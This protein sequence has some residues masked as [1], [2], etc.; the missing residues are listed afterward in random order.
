VI[1][2]NGPGKIYFWRAGWCH[3]LRRL[4]LRFILIT[5][6]LAGAVFGLDYLSVALRIP[7]REQF[8]VIRVDQLYAIPNRWNEVDWSRGD[9]VMEKCVNSLLPHYGFRSCWYVRRDTMH[10]NK[11]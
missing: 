3:C 8:S 9:P 7:H 1:S 2:V 11:F 10:V 4:L 6:C 5:V